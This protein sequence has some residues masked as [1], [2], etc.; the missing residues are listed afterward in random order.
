MFFR[1]LPEIYLI[2][3]KSKS[4]LQ[5]ILDKKYLWIHNDLAQ[6]IKDCEENNPIPENFKDILSILAQKKWGTLSE[7]TIFVD[8]FRLTN[9]FNE[10]KFFKDVPY[11]HS[12]VLKLTNDCNLSCD[13]CFSAFC[14]IC[15]KSKNKIKDVL[16]LDEWKD[17]ILNLHKFGCKSILLTG[18]ESTLYPHFRDLYD[19][20]LSLGILPT[21]CTNGL[22]ALNSYD[23]TQTHIIIPIF[24]LSNILSIIGNFKK[25]KKVTLVFC[26]RVD[27]K[28]KKLLPQ[29]WKY[30]NSST[31][32]PIIQKDNLINMDVF[33][34]F[35]RKDKNQC[36][37]GKI[38]ILENGDVY[39][40]LGA[41]T[42]KVNV[43]NNCL[44]YYNLDQNVLKDKKVG[45]VKND[46][47][48]DIIKRLMRNF[49]SHKIDNNPKCYG[50]EFRYTCNSCLF[51]DVDK[52]CTYNVEGAVWK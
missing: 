19:F 40:C 22:R 43:K 46:L 50:C 48:I 30:I 25:Y 49:W 38:A 31:C 9:I 51:N 21:I 41:C 1:L 44:S 5:N 34:F 52:N 35:A 39:P 36:L 15:F 11:I 28:T 12:A 8:K 45:N 3:G 42:S 7:K 27:E 18:G 10:K 23:T 17:T 4:L 37:N 2:N 20:I 6:I 24:N 13:N 33:N 16:S 14:P 29:N 32:Y 26:C 47:W